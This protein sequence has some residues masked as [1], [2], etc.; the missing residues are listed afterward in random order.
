MVQILVLPNEIFV[1]LTIVISENMFLEKIKSADLMKI[2][3]GFELGNVRL[4]ITP[5]NHYTNYGCGYSP[6][7]LSHMLLYINYNVKS[8]AGVRECHNQIIIYFL[9]I[10][11]SKEI[12]SSKITDWQYNGEMNPGFRDRISSHR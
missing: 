6:D 1:H 12:S 11:K 9:K 10:M 5:I 8:F 3:E 7:F 4:W 2:W